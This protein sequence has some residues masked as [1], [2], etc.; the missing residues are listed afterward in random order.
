MFLFDAN[1]AGRDW[2]GLEKHV[3]DLLGR[4]DAELEYAERWPD[5]KL[6]YEVKGCRKGTYYLTYFRAAPDEITGLHRDCE[7]SDRV[8]RVIVLLDDANEEFCD[9]RKRR[10]AEAEAKKA[11]AKTAEAKTAED[12]A[13]A[14][15]TPVAAAAPAE[16]APPAAEAPAV[17]PEPETP[18]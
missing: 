5:R 9:E 17:T 18:A 3:Q 7:L 1:V 14:A 10:D 8:L 11:E 12:S 16:A 15:P 13:P 4:H 6:A 2:P